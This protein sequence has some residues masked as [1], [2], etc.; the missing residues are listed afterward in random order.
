MMC[1]NVTKTDLLKTSYR[2]VLNQS[3]KI[4]RARYDYSKQEAFISLTCLGCR[5]CPLF[6]EL[7][8][9]SL[10]VIHKAKSCAS[11]PSIPSFLIP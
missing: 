1:K 5:S 4:N 9:P 6:S 2:I 8:A 11:E 7:Q 3:L 10:R